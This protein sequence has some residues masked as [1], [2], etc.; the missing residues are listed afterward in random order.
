MSKI[1]EIYLDWVN[2]YLTLS[3]FAEDYGI[4]EELAELLIE[5]GRK[6]HELSVPF[7]VSSKINL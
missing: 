1:I 6:L 5:E 2:N 7:T 4:S 3:R